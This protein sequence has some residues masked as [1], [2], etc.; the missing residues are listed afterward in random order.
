MRFLTE[1]AGGKQSRAVYVIWA[2][3]VDGAPAAATMNRSGRAG[4]VAL[5]VEAAERLRRD[6]RPVV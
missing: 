1:T 2:S 3:E 5:R 6:E 4:F